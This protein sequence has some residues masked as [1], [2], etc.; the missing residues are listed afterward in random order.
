MHSKDAQCS[1]D[2]WNHLNALKPHLAFLKVFF[3]TNLKPSINEGLKI[4]REL[5]L[6][7][8]VLSVMSSPV[9]LPND[10]CDVSSHNYDSRVELKYCIFIP[11]L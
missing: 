1:S 2:Q 10:C 5:D 8:Q 7:L 3:I 9:N 6:F 4:F 11:I